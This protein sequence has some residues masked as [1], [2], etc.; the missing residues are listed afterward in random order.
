VRDFVRWVEPSVLWALF[1]ATSVYG[2]VTMKLAVARAGGGSR[3]N[4]LWVSV[5]DTWGWSALLAWTGSCVMWGLTLSRHELMTANAISSF[6]YVLT[7]L[8][9]WTFLNEG[10]DGQRAAGMLFIGIGIL[11]VR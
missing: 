9:A 2:H 3:A 10:I 11:L 7:G 4:V 5:T 6:R 1:F 8:A